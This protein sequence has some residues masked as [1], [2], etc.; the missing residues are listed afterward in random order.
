MLP[1]SG[2]NGLNPRYK[3]ENVRT[4]SSTFMMQQ[5]SISDQGPT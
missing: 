4:I 1:L 3:N 5:P 2:A